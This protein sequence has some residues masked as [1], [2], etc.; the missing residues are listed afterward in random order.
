MGKLR[1]FTMGGVAHLEE[2]LGIGAEGMDYGALEDRKAVMKK[3]LQVQPL[4]ATRLI[5]RFE[6][7]YFT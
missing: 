7:G 4:V 5:N 2:D 1:E 6:Y 3:V